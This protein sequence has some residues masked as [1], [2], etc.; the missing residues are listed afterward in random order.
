[1]FVHKLR[2]ALTAVVV[3]SGLISS[4]VFAG[5]VSVAVASNFSAPMQQ[6]ELIVICLITLQW[7]LFG[8]SFYKAAQRATAGEGIRVPRGFH[9]VAG[10][11]EMLHQTLPGVLADVCEKD[12]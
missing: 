8:Y 3:L 11:G 10:A 12:G 7:V 2:S 6:I 4:P 9:I 5:E 1:M